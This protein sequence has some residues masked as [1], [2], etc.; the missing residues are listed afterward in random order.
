MNSDYDYAEENGKNMARRDRHMATKKAVEMKIAKGS[1]KITKREIESTTKSEERK[2]QNN[3]NQKKYLMSL[4]GEIVER[5]ENIFTKNPSKIP[6]VLYYDHE[7]NYNSLDLLPLDKLNTP[8][9]ITKKSTIVEYVIH[10]NNYKNYNHKNTCILNF[11]SAKNPGGAVHH[12]TGNISQEES[13]V[14]SSPDLYLA[15]AYGDGK[16]MYEKNE[17]DNKD[18]LYHCEYILTPEINLLLDHEFEQLPSPIKMAV[19]SSP[20]INY[21][22]YVKRAK[23]AGLDYETIAYNTMKERVDKLFHILAYNGYKNI[24]LGPWGCGVFGGK[25]DDLMEH[26]KTSKFVNYFNEIHFISP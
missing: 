23:R 16:E 25:V 24:V 9:F 15:L 17:F 20:A 4:A 8:Q 5:A 10:L 6:E 1:K 26:I 18:C 21:K 3:G 22:E 7:Y 12:Q 19:I 13:I 2:N 14:Y 11:A